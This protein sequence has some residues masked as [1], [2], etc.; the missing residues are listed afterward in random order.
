[1]QEKLEKDFSHVMYSKPTL[2]YSIIAQP[3]QNLF[4][5]L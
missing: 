2:M 3:T 5:V 1:M 4:F